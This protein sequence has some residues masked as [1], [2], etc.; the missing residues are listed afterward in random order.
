MAYTHKM[1]KT[2]NINTLGSGQIGNSHA[3]TTGSHVALRRNFSGL[4]SA[5]D[6]KDVASL[7]VCTLKKIF[8]LGGADFL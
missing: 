2:Y 3:K 4:V 8:W 6:Q 7:L 5:S 1:L